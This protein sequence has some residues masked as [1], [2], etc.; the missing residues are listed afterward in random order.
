ML[1]VHRLES[2]VAAVRRQANGKQ[3]IILS[4]YP[5]HLKAKKNN[6]GIFLHIVGF[7]EKAC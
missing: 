7:T 6:L 4:S 2:V 5:G 3:M 1:Q